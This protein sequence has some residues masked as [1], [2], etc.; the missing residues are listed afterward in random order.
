MNIVRKLVPWLGLFVG[1]LTCTAS[2]VETIPTS[3]DHQGAGAIAEAML[4]QSKVAMGGWAWDKICRIKVQEDVHV[5]QLAGTME[6]LTDLCAKRMAGSAHVGPFQQAMGYDGQ[7]YWHSS[8]GNH[9]VVHKPPTPSE[10]TQL[11]QNFSAWW[12]PKRWPAKIVAAGRVSRQGKTF[13]IIH[14]IPKGGVALDLWIDAKSHLIAQLVTTEDKDKITTQWDDYRD[15]Q[16]I[17]L[18]FRTLSI[19]SG[20]QARQLS[21]VIQVHLNT[22]VTQKNFD[23]P[24]LHTAL[25]L[26]AGADQVSLPFEFEHGYIYLPVTIQGQHFRFM[27]D[28]GGTNVLSERVTKELGLASQGQATGMGLGSGHVA[29]A[30]TTVKHISLGHQLSFDN[31]TFAVQPMLDAD[32]AIGGLELFNGYVASID[33]AAR[34]VILIRSAAFHPDPTAIRLPL[35]D[36]HQLPAVWASVG[37]IGGWFVLDTGFNDLMDLLAPFSREHNLYRLFHAEQGKGKIHG[38]DGVIQD[39]VAHNQPFELGPIHA[40]LPEFTLGT[41][42]K[43]MNGMEGVAGFIGSGVLKHLVTTFDDSDQVVYLKPSRY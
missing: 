30:F 8:N 26:P 22:S 13:D 6:Y 24:V 18:P 10:V 2:C 35:H 16:G 31:Q 11:Y 36:V 38:Y 43:G 7:S 15:V 27:L 28:S 9:L 34:K 20:Q 32:G 12:Y 25:S 4:A 37:G 39:L 29:Q 42:T 19:P 21:Q 17:Q 40:Q 41:D 3:A 1:G 5:A 33:Y 14:I 23:T